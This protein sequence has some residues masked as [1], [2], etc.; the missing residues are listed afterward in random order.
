[1]RETFTVGG[2]VSHK[3][4]EMQKC[5]ALWESFRKMKNFPAKSRSVTQDTKLPRKTKKSSTQ[6]PIP[7]RFCV[8]SGCRVLVCSGTR[9]DTLLLSQ[10]GKVYNEQWKLS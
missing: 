4:A 8:D 5:H 7:A 9:C 10:R 1:M 6:N 2:K 3:C